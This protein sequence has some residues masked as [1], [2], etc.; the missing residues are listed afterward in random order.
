VLCRVVG[1]IWVYGVCESGFSV[2]RD[3]Q[4]C[5]CSVDSYVQVVDF[6]VLLCFVGE[7]QFRVDRVEV[8]KYYVYV[9]KLLVKNQENVIDITEVVHTFVFAGQVGKVCVCSMC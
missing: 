2:N 8:I 1:G 5:G 4:V 7:L 6:V 9:G 3:I